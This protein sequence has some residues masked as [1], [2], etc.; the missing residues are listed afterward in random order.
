ML[1]EKKKIAITTILTVIALLIGIIPVVDFML[2]TGTGEQSHILTF[3]YLVKINFFHWGWSAGFVF[4]G[5]SIAGV[6]LW[7]PGLLLF[8]VFAIV[9][10]IIAILLSAHWLFW[11]IAIMNLPT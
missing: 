3:E 1:T 11:V 2:A 4:A 6:V 7:K 10:S 9:I 5:F 8:R